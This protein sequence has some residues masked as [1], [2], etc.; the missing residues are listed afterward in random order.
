MSALLCRLSPAD[1]AVPALPCRLLLVIPILKLISLSL[2]RCLTYLTFRFTGQSEGAWLDAFPPGGG[3][4]GGQHPQAVVPWTVYAIKNAPLLLRCDLGRLQA[5]LYRIPPPILPPYDYYTDGGDHPDDG[6]VDYYDLY[7]DD[8]APAPPRPVSRIYD[9]SGRLAGTANAAENRPL[10]QQVIS[11]H[12]KNDSLLKVNENV[13]NDIDLKYQDHYR[14]TV[15]TA[16]AA[17]NDAN[18]LYRSLTSAPLLP[19]QAATILPQVF[20]KQRDAEESSNVINQQG[21]ELPLDQDELPTTV[22]VASTLNG[23]IP[24]ATP[25]SASSTTASSP[26]SISNGGTAAWR[27]GGTTA[28]P[29]S[30][31]SASTVTWLKDD[32]IIRDRR[33]ITTASGHLNI[34]RVRL[35]GHHNFAFLSLYIFIWI[36]L[37]FQQCSCTLT[38]LGTY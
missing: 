6:E 31:Y 1:L 38:S 20:P 8:Q 4:P 14:R 3:G 27:P 10:H 35:T 5:P 23:A 21:D 28:I 25:T 13:S 15:R 37:F 33:H 30:A 19:E 36:T 11:N 29:D 16:S 18:N 7:N 9:G 17:E 24:T 22:A 12:E 26:H 32:M 34:T 2:F